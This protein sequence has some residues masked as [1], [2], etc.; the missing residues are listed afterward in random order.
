MPACAVAIRRHLPFFAACKSRATSLLRSFG[1]RLSLSGRPGYHRFFSRSEGGIST[2]HRNS[3]QDPE[4]GRRFVRERLPEIP[5]GGYQMK[6]ARA[7]IWGGKCHTTTTTGDEEM[8][9]AHW[10]P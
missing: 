2:G 1:T 6:T 4:R 8:T 3:E 10:R 7:F 5:G 9:L